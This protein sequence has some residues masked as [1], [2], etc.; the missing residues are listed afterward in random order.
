MQGDPEKVPVPLP[1]QDPIESIN[2]PPG[3]NVTALPAKKRKKTK[4]KKKAKKAAKA[5]PRSKVKGKIKKK[6]KKRR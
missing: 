6:S 1:V 3:S 4:K 2:E 5:K